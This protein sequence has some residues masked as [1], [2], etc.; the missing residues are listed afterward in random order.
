MEKKKGFVSAEVLVEVRFW[1]TMVAMLAI[2]WI[3]F[4]SLPPIPAA[5][6]GLRI[7]FWTVV[8]IMSVWFVVTAYRLHRDT[9]RELAERGKRFAE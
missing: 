1:L 7:F 2:L 5:H 4:L 8:S 6:M 3:A 9:E